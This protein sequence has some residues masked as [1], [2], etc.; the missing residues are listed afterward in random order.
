MNNK[1]IVT[2]NNPLSNKYRKDSISIGIKSNKL[3][4]L[5]FVGYTKGNSVKDV[6]SEVM[7]ILNLNMVIIINFLKNLF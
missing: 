5:K 2:K 6:P 1:V 7:N 4:E 3:K